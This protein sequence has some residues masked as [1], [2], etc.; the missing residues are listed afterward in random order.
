MQGIAIEDAGRPQYGDGL[1]RGGKRNQAY[2]E[3]GREKTA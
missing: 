1:R 3:T 2:D